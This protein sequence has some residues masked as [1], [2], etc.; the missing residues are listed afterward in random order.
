MCQTVAVADCNNSGVLQ[1]GTMLRFCAA[2]HKNPAKIRPLKLFA[3]KWHTAVGLAIVLGFL[4][5]P[6]LPVWRL[7]EQIL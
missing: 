5:Y 1:A 4:V 7:F 2:N 6:H 3:V